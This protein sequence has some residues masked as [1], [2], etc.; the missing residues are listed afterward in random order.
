M[1]ETDFPLSWYPVALLSQLKGGPLPFTLFGEDYFLFRARNGALCAMSRYCAHMGADL[2]RAQVVGDGVRCGLHGWIYGTDGVCRHVPGTPHGTEARLKRLAVHEA[3]GIVF[4]WPGPTPAWPFPDLPGIMMPRAARPRVIAFECPL[5]AVG[6]NGFD[7]WHYSIIHRRRVRPGIEIGRHADHHISLCFTAD[8]M[9]GRFHDDMVIRLGSSQL[10]VKLDYWGGNIIY[11]RNVKS[12][13]LAMI[14]LAPLGL[15]R[16]QIYIAVFIER[17]D[18]LAASVSQS[19]RL[20]IFRW[21]AYRFLKSDFPYVAGMRPSDGML[22][23]GKDDLAREF[24]LW[25][26]KLPRLGSLPP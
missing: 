19:I 26:R 21:V 18:G 2:S 24:W 1:H 25:W 20:E 5:E 6:L 15:G 23:D 12:N 22:I 4:V 3:G 17:R 11:V 10:D 8:V 9:P 7:I 14:A 16:C 13:Y